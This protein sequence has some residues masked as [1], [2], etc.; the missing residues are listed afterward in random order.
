MPPQANS[1]VMTLLRSAPRMKVRAGALLT[2][3]RRKSNVLRLR[4][5]WAPLQISSWVEGG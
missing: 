4:M 1:S 5:S 3:L 2:V